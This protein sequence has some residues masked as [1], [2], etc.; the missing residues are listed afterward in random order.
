MQGR[1]R[2]VAH[3]V[4]LDAG[5]RLEGYQGRTTR[6]VSWVRQA[7]RTAHAAY[8]KEI[9]LRKCGAAHGPVVWRPE[10]RRP[11]R[12]EFLFLI[13]GVHGSLSYLVPYPSKKKN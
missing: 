3:K 10:T 9:A 8:R 12:R 13:D 5:R 1:K 6:W 2:F 7:G 11:V 4:G